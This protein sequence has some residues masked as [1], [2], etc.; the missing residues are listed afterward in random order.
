[1]W[2]REFVVGMLLLLGVLGFAGWQWWQAESNKANYEAGERAI[3]L[4]HWDEAQSYFQAAHDYKDAAILAHNAAFNVSERNKHYGA[5][6]TYAGQQ[7]WVRA[8]EEISATRKIQ[9]DYR[10]LPTLGPAIESHVYDDSLLGVVVQWPSANPPGLYY[11]AKSG[12]VWLR[13]SDGTSHAQYTGR[14]DMFLFDMPAPAGSDTGATPHNVGSTPGQAGSTNR[15]TAVAFV[16][17]EITT[18]TL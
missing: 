12:W 5:A 13:G 4:N 15:V 10:D 1:V 16:A 8:F 9:P 3:S 6:L 11:R 18:A 7:E 14:T 17:P 2:R